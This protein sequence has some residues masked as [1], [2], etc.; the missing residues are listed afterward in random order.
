MAEAIFRHKV[1]KRTDAGEWIID[2]AGTMAAPGFPPTPAVPIVLDE[3]EIPFEE[4][5]SQP[6]YKALLEQFQL[7]LAMESTH[8]RMMQ[9]FYPANSPRIKLLSEMVGDVY[10]IPDPFGS[11]LGMYRTLGHQLNEL[12][13]RG[14]ESIERLAN[15]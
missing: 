14:M 8:L 12:I 7:I 1:S 3:M 11:D 15:H 13:D 2:S 4:H 6:V 9:E 10:G 5:S